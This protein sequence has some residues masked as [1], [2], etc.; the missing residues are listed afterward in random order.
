MGAVSAF[1]SCERFPRLAF[2]RMFRPSDRKS[3]V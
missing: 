2:A 1:F 3:V